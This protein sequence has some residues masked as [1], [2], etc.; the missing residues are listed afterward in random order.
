MRGGEPGRPSGPGASLH[1]PDSNEITLEVCGIVYIYNP[2]NTTLLNLNNPAGP[3][4]IV[5]GG[6]NQL[7]LAALGGKGSG[8]N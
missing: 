2:A 6:G 8:P 3:V 4:A 7:P 1:Q 5:P